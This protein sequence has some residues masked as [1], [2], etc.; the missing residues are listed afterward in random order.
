M[1]SGSCRARAMPMRASAAPSQRRAF[2]VREDARLVGQKGPPELDNGVRNRVK[3][4]H[5]VFAHPLQD[6]LQPVHEPRLLL[7]RVFIGAAKFHK[8]LII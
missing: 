8:N 6:R 5:L 1:P 4:A 3:V 7:A 2:K